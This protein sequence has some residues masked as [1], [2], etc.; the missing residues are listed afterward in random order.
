MDK[1][2]KNIN[3]SLLSN[4][5]LDY[6]SKMAQYRDEIS[7]LLSAENL[8]TF[9][10]KKESMDH[11]LREMV[12]ADMAMRFL[13]QAYG[14]DLP[15]I[16]PSKRAMDYVGGPKNPAT[17]GEEVTRAAASRRRAQTEELA[18]KELY[19]R[20]S[21]AAIVAPKKSNENKAKGTKAKK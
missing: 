14:D 5:W 20:A 2:N 17:K 4:I 3:Q 11:T 21:A 13:H 7:S 8:A 12:S 15:V 10:D 9:T 19:D 18:R 1:K 16:T 6:N